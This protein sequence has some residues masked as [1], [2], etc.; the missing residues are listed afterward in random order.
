MHTKGNVPSIEVLTLLKRVLLLLRTHGAESWSK[1]WPMIVIMAL[2]FSMNITDVYVAGI[3]GSEMQATVGFVTQLYFLLILFGNAMTVGTVAIV[4]RLFGAGDVERLRIVST[5]LLKGFLMAGAVLG[6]AGFIFTPLIIDLAGI[7][8]ELKEPGR[9][10]LRIYSLGLPG[11]YLFIFLHALFRSTSRMKTSMMIM[12][13]GAVMNIGLT[14][15]LVLHT[16]LGYPGLALSTVMSVVT[17]S[18]ASLLLS[19]DCLEKGHSMEKD[20]LSRVFRIGWPSGLLQLSWQGGSMVIFLILASVPG[21]A[22]AVMA[23]FTNGL[24]IESAIFMPAFAISMGNA[25]I[26]GTLLG[27]ARKDDAP[28]AGVTTAIMGVLLV[29]ILAL[30]VVLAAPLLASLLS[31]DGKVIERSV[32]YL[33]IS[34]ISEPFMAWAAILSGALNGA[35]DTRP[36]LASVLISIWGIRIPLCFLFGVILTLDVTFIWWSMNLSMAVHALLISRRYFSR[37][38]VT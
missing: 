10:L 25:V 31:D 22:V 2:Q 30:V 14:F 34:M 7:P 38:W 8:E 11:N 13:A 3:L 28:A 21:E 23:A 19:R 6:A 36:V 5:T 18:V 15:A 35:G 29:T 32:E 4:T 1:S 27:G 16:P 33:Y 12:A 20:I 17:F 9:Q 26:T 24:R 37:K